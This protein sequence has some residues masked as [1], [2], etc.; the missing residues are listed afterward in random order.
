[1]CLGMSLVLALYVGYR[2]GGAIERGIEWP[3]WLL[4]WV[5]R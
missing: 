3:R 1:M 4:R 5:N 2:L